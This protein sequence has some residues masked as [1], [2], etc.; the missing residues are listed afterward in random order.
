MSP[1]SE[2]VEATSPNEKVAL[3]NWKRLPC[4]PAEVCM[5]QCVQP[6]VH[7]REYIV[8]LDGTSD[9]L[10][11]YHIKMGIWSTLIS[12]RPFNSAEGCPLAVF[13]ASHDDQ[14][15]ILVSNFGR[16]YKYFVET[17]RWKI[18]D[19]LN[20]Y[21]QLQ[22]NNIITTTYSI[23]CV[24]LATVNTTMSSDQPQ[25]SV[26][27]LWQEDNSESSDVHLYLRRF[28]NSEWTDPIELKGTYAFLDEEVSHISYAISQ[29]NLYVNIDAYGGSDIYCINNQNVMSTIPLPTLLTKTTICSVK[30][31][32]FSFGGQ[33]E[34]DEQ[35]QP[36][37]D[38]NRYNPGTME[39]EP[40]GYMRS[41]RYSVIV[42]PIL[43]DKADKIFVVGGDFG[44]VTDSDS[45][46]ELTH[47][48]RI[49]EIC[50]IS[51]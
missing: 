41:C 21:D 51:P 3:T 48:C 37:S 46:T 7:W 28:Q 47:H 20:T 6:G 13:G 19:K 9:R 39:W 11:L 45:E 35:E 50:D 12:K 4:V 44:E 16:I 18:F 5:S 24:F 23:K 40:A 33:V 34:D 36:S 25:S 10:Y 2:K 43:L 32:M 38:V 1:D 8:F 14:D 29:S 15:L 26:L 49:A 22:F 30:D 42:T 27:L 17:G 31:T